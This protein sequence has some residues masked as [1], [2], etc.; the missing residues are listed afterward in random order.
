MP[1]NNS[2]SAWSKEI[3]RLRK[4]V[5][6]IDRSLLRLL[7]QRTSLS[8]EIGQTKRRHCAEI[9][10][11]DRERELLARVEEIGGGRLPAGALNAI[12]REIMSSSRA[13]QG[14][15]PIGILAG[16][17]RAISSA[18]RCHFGACD[19]FVPVRN[20][21]D[22]SR[23]L[24]AGK[25]AVGLLTFEDMA[26]ALQDPYAGGLAVLG[27]FAGIQNDPLIEQRIF[28]VKPAWPEPKGNR[29]LILIECKPTIDQVKSLVSAMPRVPKFV[30]MSPLPGRGRKALTLA[31]LTFAQPID[32][33]ALNT[34]GRP[35]GLVLGIYTV[36]E[37]HAG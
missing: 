37:S 23:Q 33:E 2:K 3:Q 17:A 16:S 34:G 31:A 36:D 4:Q 26:V 21:R 20:W 9:Y 24:R 19:K 12:Y 8:G 1:P 18:A 27:D 13:A 29:A 6:R 11:P 32:G 25:L 30:Q 15:P 7:Q 22:L 14:Q 5:D 10:V 28:V 35:I